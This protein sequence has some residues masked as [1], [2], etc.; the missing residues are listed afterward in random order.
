MFWIQEGLAFQLGKCPRPAGF[1]LSIT[2]YQ[3]VVIQELNK[4]TKLSNNCPVINNILGE[5]CSWKTVLYSVQ[6]VISSVTKVFY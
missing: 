4:Y 1:S 5:I 2:R 3:H 6:I